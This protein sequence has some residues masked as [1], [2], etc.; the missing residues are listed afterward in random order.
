MPITFAHPAAILPLAFIKRKWWSYTGLIIGSVI[1]DFEGFMR[2]GGQ[3]VYSHTWEGMFWFDLPLGLF[4]AF[5]FHYVVR[6]AAID[7]MPGPLYRRFVFFRELN[8]NLYALRNFLK[9]VISMLIGITTHLLWDRVTHTDSYG[10]VQK[11]G[12][13]LPPD[14][15]I[16]L[17]QTLQYVSSIVGMLIMGWWIWSLPKSDT[18]RTTRLW[19][20]YW[21]VIAVSG[22]LFYLVVQEHLPGHVDDLIN[23]V[24]A[25][26]LIGWVLMSVLFRLVNAKIKSE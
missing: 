26:S 5:L 14:E 21:P 8:W 7:N 16:E 15:N 18:A 13:V 2:L 22:F 3:K 12:I 24:I 17:R 11:V 25:G 10:Y 4:V 19:W 1:P 20:P 23:S 6:D 9:L